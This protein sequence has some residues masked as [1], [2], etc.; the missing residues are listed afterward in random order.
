MHGTQRS[1]SDGH[2]AAVAIDKILRLAIE[3]L[4]LSFIFVLSHDES[5]S[6]Q[7]YVVSGKG[8]SPL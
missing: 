4:M 5:S 7:T 1:V 6:P 2:H 8:I 3:H